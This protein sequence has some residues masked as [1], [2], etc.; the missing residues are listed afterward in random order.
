MI[1]RP[2][3]KC[4]ATHFGGFSGIPALLGRLDRDLI[5]SPNIERVGHAVF[6]AHHLLEELDTF[7]RSQGSA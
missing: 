1:D 5:R 2:I 4:V 7:R 3:A 6:Q